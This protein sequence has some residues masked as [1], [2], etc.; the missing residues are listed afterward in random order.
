MSHRI[1]TLIGIAC[2]L[3]L[4]SWFGARAY[5]RADLNSR[6]TELAARDVALIEPVMRIE[7][8][9][10]SMK[11]DDLFA[12]CDRVFETEAN[13]VSDASGYRPEI[14]SP[15]RTVLIEHLKDEASFVRAKRDVY[16]GE[17]ETTNLV[18]DFSDVG[19]FSDNGM[20]RFR[21]R[22]IETD[23]AYG[24][25]GTSIARY[26]EA[27]AKA[28][29]SERTLANYCRSEICGKLF[30]K[31]KDANLKHIEGP[32]AEVKRCKPRTSL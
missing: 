11:F 24:S 18:M 32:E 4:G 15:F 25:L 17:L 30:A 13:L 29:A 1:L 26:K 7:A 5:R 31:F 16:R 3:T 2:L 9:N 6:L 28:E 23:S 27:F 10:I 14:S 12:M 22:M 19:D 21:R 8:D 20:R